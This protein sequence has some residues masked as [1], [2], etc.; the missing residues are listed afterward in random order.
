MLQV[1]TNSLDVGIAANWVDVP[2]S[3]EIT[4]TNITINPANPT[5]FFRLRAP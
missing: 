2:A 3:I 4:A 5:A 1:Q